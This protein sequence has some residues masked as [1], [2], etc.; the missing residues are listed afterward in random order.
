MD[1]VVINLGTN[2]I[3]YITYDPEARNAEFIEAYQEFLTT[4][5]E[6]HP[7]AAIICTVGTMGGNEIYDLIGQAVAEFGDAKVSC[8]F[9]QTHTMADGMGADWHPSAK[10]QQNSA[11]VLAD[12]ICQALGIE[13]DQ[14]GLNVAADAEYSAASA[15][16]TN[17]WPYVS[18]YDKSFSV[19]IVSGG[20]SPSDVE[21]TLSGIGLKE[22]GKYVLSF[23]Y[24]TGIETTFPVLVRG[25]EVYL[26]EM[27]DGDSSEKHFEA[28]FTASANDTVQIVFQLGGKDGYNTML[29]N[30][31]L[32]KIG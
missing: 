24:S 30:I 7:D 28:T 20:G 19:N 12:K 14:M 1:A 27:A 18:D 21:A 29:R 9:S 26:S 3:N 32:T 16:G 22:G 8:Y 23:D 13:S 5:R 17:I 10:T 25:N 15:E 31:K 11:Y 2:D 4:V 6:K